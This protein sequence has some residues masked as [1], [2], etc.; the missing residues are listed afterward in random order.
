MLVLQLKLFVQ[1]QLAHVMSRADENDPTGTI[2]FVLKLLTISVDEIASKYESDSLASVAIIQ[3]VS[4]KNLFGRNYPNGS[5]TAIERKPGSRIKYLNS[6]SITQVGRRSKIAE[7]EES[8]GLLELQ[9]IH[10]QTSLDTHNSILDEILSR[11]PLN[12]GC[13]SGSGF[14]LK[15]GAS[16]SVPVARAGNIASISSGPK[17]WLD[18]D[19]VQAPTARDKPQEYKGVLS[20]RIYA[21][22]DV[23][24]AQP[25]M[26][27]RARVTKL[28][29]NPIRTRIPTSSH[30]LG[31]SEP[32][33]NSTATV[34]KSSMKG[35]SLD[36]TEQDFTN[37]QSDDVGSETTSSVA[38]V[39][40]RDYATPI[41]LRM[42]LV[43][44]D[45]NMA[46]PDTKS[47]LDGR[48]PGRV[49]EQLWQELEKAVLGKGA[50][51]NLSP[52][53]Q[54]RHYL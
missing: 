24:D 18:R 40:A 31:N 10:L 17:F 48:T 21:A 3:G 43:N 46:T 50:D 5:G 20:S 8:I 19:V 22:G 36:A 44:G 14:S 30:Y 47:S 28:V 35:P 9:A 11:L 53:V 1:R 32:G 37:T 45:R 51:S 7:L 16:G 52:N 15:K 41:A 4:Q 49:A 27:P 34:P 26:T 42:G 12:R 54:V 6:Q 39:I 29:K 2:L 33:Q 25:I 13:S 23:V 38:A